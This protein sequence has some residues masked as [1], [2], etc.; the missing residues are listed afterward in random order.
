MNKRPLSVTIIG[1]LVIVTSIFSLFS[2]LMMGSNPQASAMLA[3]SP[4]PASAHQIVGI[5]STLISLISGYGILKGFNWARI[6]YIAAGIAGLLF[7]LLTVPMV[8]VIIL[9]VLMLAVVAFFLFR[10]AA[11]DWFNRR[12]V[13]AEQ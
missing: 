6:L 11:N 2:V 1:W 13:A 3:E 7:S 5:V 4:L 8:S 10:P 9:G 12:P